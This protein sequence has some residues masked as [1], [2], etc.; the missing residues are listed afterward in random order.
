MQKNQKP[1]ED[2]YMH[3]VLS[4]HQNTALFS[5]PLWPSILVSKMEITLQKTVRVT[6]HEPTQ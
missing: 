1:V 5:Q 6:D 4:H 3:M 2:T